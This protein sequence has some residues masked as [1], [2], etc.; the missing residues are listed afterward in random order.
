MGYYTQ[1]ELE[2]DN[3][4]IQDHIEGIEEQS[5][6]SGLFEDTVKWYGHEKDM[7]AYSA[8]HPYVL[9]TLHGDGED[10]EDFWVEYHKDGK[11]Q[12]EKAVISFGEFDES[13]LV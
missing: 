9:F 1:H 12:R 7:K 8:K 11:M 4:Y 5:G 2:I 10:S 13:K 6:Y 3:G